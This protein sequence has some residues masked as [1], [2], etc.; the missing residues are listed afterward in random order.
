M[1]GSLTFSRREEVPPGPATLDESA[2]L[3][4]TAGPSSEVGKELTMERPA[5]R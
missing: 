3:A 4:I 2:I 1:Q 5:Y